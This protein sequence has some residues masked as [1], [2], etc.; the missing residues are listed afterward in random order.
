MIELAVCGVCF[1]DEQDCCCRYCKFC[2]ERVIPLYT[3]AGETCPYC[4]DLLGEKPEPDD[5]FGAV[6]AQEDTTNLQAI[7]R[8]LSV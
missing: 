6:R 8:G 7:N 3:L 4:G 2:N 1:E 5:Y